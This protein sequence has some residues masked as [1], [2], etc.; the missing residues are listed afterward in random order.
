MFWVFQSGVN[1]DPGC[2]QC[3]IVSLSKW[4]PTLCRDMSS[5]SLSKVQGPWTLKYEGNMFFK[6]VGTNFPTMYNTSQKT[7]T[8]TEN[9]ITEWTIPIVYP[10]FVSYKWPIEHASDIQPIGHET[11]CVQQ[12]VNSCLMD[13]K[14]YI[15]Y[16]D[17]S[18]DAVQGNSSC[19]L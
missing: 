7:G 16:K 8:V 9:L 11:L 2:L 5:S 6:M 14:V 1:K 15:H 3:D 17:W 10:V 13:N 4:L 18:E 12:S 19:L